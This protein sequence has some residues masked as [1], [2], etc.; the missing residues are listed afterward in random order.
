MTEWS[1]LEIDWVN[2]CICDENGFHS[3]LPIVLTYRRRIMYIN[4]IGQESKYTYQSL[5]EIHKASRSKV[6][7][8]LSIVM[9]NF[10][11]QFINDFKI[12]IN[13]MI[14]KWLIC[15]IHR[16]KT[17]PTGDEQFIFS[18]RHGLAIP[19]TPTYQHY[20]SSK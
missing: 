7:I 16:Y 6:K 5:V 13:T 15:G 2:S 14:F 10:W 4:Y 11:Q 8:Y 19:A 18:S 3:I 9:Q 17:S 20:P 1:Q 12:A